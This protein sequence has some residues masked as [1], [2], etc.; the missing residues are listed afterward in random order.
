MTGRL[1]GKRVVLVGAGQTP[2]ATM[3]IGRATALLFAREGARLLLADRDTA[4]A[5]ETVSLMEPDTQEVSI[6][7]A[8]ITRAGD[9]ARLADEARA[10]LGGVDVLFNS[11]GILGPG[12]AADVTEEVWDNVIETNLKAMWLVAKHVLP[13]MVEQRGGSFVAV[14]SIGA[15]RG[16]TSAAYGISKAGVSRLVKSVAATYGRYDIRANAILPGLIDTP[17]AID[18]AVADTG[19]SRDELARQREARVPMAYK[20]SAA[21]VAYAALFFASDESRFVSGT[22]LPVDGAVL[23]A[24]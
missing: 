11:V 4:S 1:H 3:G 14:S 13:I 6:L 15:E 19:A 5:A 18:A 21:D 12:L 9:C 7:E 17:M 10:R 16:G 24:R 20:G 22:C 2:G 23:A 8:D